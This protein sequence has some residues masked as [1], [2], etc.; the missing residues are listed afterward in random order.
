MALIK[1]IAA[2]FA[3]VTAFVIGAMVMKFAVPIDLPD[4]LQHMAQ[5]RHNTYSQELMDEIKAENIDSNLK[6]FSEKP[7][8]AGSPQDEEVL[9]GHIYNT[10]KMNLDS[11][12]NYIYTV[13]LSY[14]NASD[15]NYVSILQEDGTEVEES[16]KREKVLR[17]GQ[18]DP[19]VVN[20]FNS[21]SPAGVVLGE[22]VYVN[23][24]DVGDFHYLARNLSL[25]L[26][27]RVAI[28][29]YGRIFRGD[30]VKN[31]QDWGCAGVILYSDPADY[32]AGAGARVYPD[33]WWLPGTAV[34]RGTTLRSSGDPLTP[35]Y[36]SI[37]SAFFLE[38]K[39]A[40]LPTIPV[41]PIGYDDAV[42]YLSKL[43]GEEVPPAWRGHL[44]ITYRLGP[45]FKVPFEKSKI[46]LYVQTYNV[47][48]EIKNVIGYIRGQYEPDRYVVLGNHRDAWVYGGIDPSSGTAAMME[49]SR[50]MG[51][52][53]KKGW[54]PRRSIIFCSWAAEEYGLIGSTEWVEELNKILGSRTIAYLNV[55][56]A[57]TGNDSLSAMAT[58]ALYTLLYEAAKRVE[59][60]NPAEVAAG[61]KSVFDTWLAQNPSHYNQSAP[62]IDG[63]G[64]G[65]DHTAFLQLA[66]IPVLDVSYA[67][68]KAYPISSYPMYHSA[69]ETYDLV[70]RLMDRGFKFHQAVARMWGE[71]AL[72]LADRVLLRLDCL[73]YASALQRITAEVEKTEG[74]LLQS[75]NIS[76]DGVKSA[77]ADFHEAATTLH[78]KLGKINL[79]NPLEVRRVNDQLMQLERAFIDPLGTARDLMHRHIIY[80]PNQKN[81]Y[82]SSRFPGLSNALFDIENDEQQMWRWEQVKK[83]VS[84]IVFTIRSAAST[85]RDASDIGG[86]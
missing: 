80:A 9:A 13:L 46:K 82:A 51:K 27:G 62:H 21:Y 33:D 22:L 37:D 15:P 55:D 56:L 43:G 78:A 75:W 5:E 30:K 38:E 28:A 19:T 49:V 7:H 18:N 71:M 67:F 54:R 74:P 63:P 64:S 76:L 36:P 34:Q 41:T 20:P 40:G 86:L 26:T 14:P 57:L 72:T 31:A 8:M 59:N 68:G 10:W 17:M 39:D 16:A 50:A 4:W 32:V 69:Y 24:G 60:P 48:K 53:L 52:L 61:R 85:L 12:R 77:A 47:R 35:F 42:K 44:N 6:F 70:S 83:E 79:K 73:E 23:Y 29:R 11:A 1:C 2:A 84:I 25:D 81:I 65:S 3:V 58:P 66:G 45:G